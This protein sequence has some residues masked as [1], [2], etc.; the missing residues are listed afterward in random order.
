MKKIIITAIC[1]AAFVVALLAAFSIG[2]RASADEKFRAAK[3]IV[4][5]DSFFILTDGKCYSTIPKVVG[6]K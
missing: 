4:K 3:I 5:G 6:E 2:K 1:S